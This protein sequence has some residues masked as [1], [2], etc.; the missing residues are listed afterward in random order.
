[1]PQIPYFSDATR[2]RDTSLIGVQKAEQG[3]EAGEVGAHAL[4]P[5]VHATRFQKIKII[6]LQIRGIETVDD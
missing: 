1:L 6:S 5:A 3:C 2:L 4:M